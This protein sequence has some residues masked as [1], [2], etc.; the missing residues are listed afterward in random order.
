MRPFYYLLIAIACINF[1]YAISIVQFVVW[2]IWPELTPS[3]F[4]ASCTVVAY[5]L[6]GYMQL[7]LIERGVQ[8]GDLMK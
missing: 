3:V 6:N 7:F 2:A 8:L 1:I 4:V 5:F